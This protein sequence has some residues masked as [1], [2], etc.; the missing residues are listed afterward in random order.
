MVTKDAINCFEVSRKVMA[1]YPKDDIIIGHP[2]GYGNLPLSDY[3]EDIIQ[4]FDGKDAI[5]LSVIKVKLQSIY[6][7]VVDIVK[8]DI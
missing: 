7:D 4:L 1:D 8:I 5:E 2:S 6:A 3:L